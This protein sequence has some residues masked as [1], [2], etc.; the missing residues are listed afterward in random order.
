MLVSPTSPTKRP[1]VAEFIVKEEWMQRYSREEQASR[2]ISVILMITVAIRN[3]QKETP[4]HCEDYA[5]SASKLP[6]LRGQNQQK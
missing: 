4:P 5:R 1:L 6:A 2:N 3:G